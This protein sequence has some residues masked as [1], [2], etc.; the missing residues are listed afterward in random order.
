MIYKVIIT[1]VFVEA[2]LQVTNTLWWPWTNIFS[3]SYVQ[4]GKFGY[5]S[6][7]LSHRKYNFLQYVNISD[8]N[9]MYQSNPSPWKLTSLRCIQH[10]H[11]PL[12]AHNQ[13]LIE[14]PV[15]VTTISNHF[16]YYNNIFLTKTWSRKE[17]SMY[18]NTKVLFFH[19]I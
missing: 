3:V 10:S 15:Y 12:H 17:D 6:L 19:F 7:H 16:W 13:T 4:Y 5:S 1:R 11:S 14:I 18:I 8:E 9:A 2:I